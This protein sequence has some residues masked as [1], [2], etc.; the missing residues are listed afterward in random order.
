[1]LVCSWDSR[2]SVIVVAIMVVRSENFI[3]KL[4]QL[5]HEEKVVVEIGKDGYLICKSQ[6]FVQFGRSQMP[7]VTLRIEE[8]E[9]VLKVS[10]GVGVTARIAYSYGFEFLKLWNENH[11]GMAAHL[12]HD[13]IPL[14]RFAFTPPTTLRGLKTFVNDVL[15]PE[16]RRGSEFCA[17]FC[18]GAWKH[19]D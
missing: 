3:Q 14:C 1:M 12:S 16:M 11:P 7:Y 19:L 5:L 18:E 2:N 15:L 10:T 17:K 9:L 8:D 6:E 4:M 13:A